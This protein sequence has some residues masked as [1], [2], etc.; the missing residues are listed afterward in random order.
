MPALM[1]SAVL[2]AVDATA[3]P[4]LPQGK[5]AYGT[6]CGMP[7]APATVPSS[8]LEDWQVLVA[9]PLSFPLFRCQEP[10]SIAK[11][12]LQSHTELC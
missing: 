6:E 7:P 8:T 1:D 10:V 3:V 9:S 4:P 5:A 2:L 11:R 12:P